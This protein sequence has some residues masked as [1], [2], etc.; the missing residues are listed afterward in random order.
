MT[1]IVITRHLSRISVIWLKNFRKLLNKQY[2]KG[3]FLKPSSRLISIC[4]GRHP[5]GFNSKFYKYDSQLVT[6]EYI[7]F[8]RKIVFFFKEKIQGCVPIS[9]GR[10]PPLFFHIRFWYSS[11]TLWLPVLLNHK[12]KKSLSKTMLRLRISIKISIFG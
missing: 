7:F 8:F 1:N 2:S 3:Y 12:E 9:V 11:Q 6:T 10:T 5:L 4:L